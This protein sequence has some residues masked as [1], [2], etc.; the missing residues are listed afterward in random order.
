MNTI[1]PASRRSTASAQSL[2]AAV[3]TPSLALLIAVAPVAHAGPWTS[4]ASAGVPDEDSL[5]AAIM[6]APSL[7]VSSTTLSRTVR[8]RYNVTDVFDRQGFA[9]PVKMS[10]R[11]V[12]NGSD[13]SVVLQLFEHDFTTGVVRLLLTLNSNSFAPSSAAQSQSVSAGCLF[14]LNFRRSAYWVEATLTRAT[15]AALPALHQLR[16]DD[17]MLC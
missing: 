15:T 9:G 6:A 5:G 4:A 12:D 7:T 16:I 14:S 13:A 3:L 10:A 2:R 17:Q 1:I 11:F 8:M